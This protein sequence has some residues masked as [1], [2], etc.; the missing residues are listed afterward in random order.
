MDLPEV[1]LRRGEGQRLASGKLAFR[2]T[3]LGIP[4]GMGYAHTEPS[5]VFLRS[6][7]FYWFSFILNFY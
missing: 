6:R 3:V 4:G 1:K 2:V 7:V 5:G